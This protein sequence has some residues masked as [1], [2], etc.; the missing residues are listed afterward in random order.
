MRNTNPEPGSRKSV[1]ATDGRPIGQRA[2]AT[3]RRLLDETRSLLSRQGLSNLRL[4]EITRASG[5]STATFYQY[6]TD[7]DDA[8]LALSEDLV[9]DANELVGLLSEPWT[10]AADKPKVEAFV[11][12]YCRYWA[13]NDSVLR[14]RNLKS[15]ESDPRF[16]EVRRRAQTPLA[17]AL[18]NKVEASITAGSVSSDQA[19]YATAAAALAA[20]ERLVTYRQR[21]N[22]RGIDDQAL[23][24]SLTNLFMQIIVGVNLVET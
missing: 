13:D 1:T 16:R 8:L 23:V 17:D 24:N 3:R 18:T 20:L 4:V 21:F 11:V 14:V 7:I 22:E 15:E 9:A 19:P 12:A 6:F 2:Q 5:A 10:S